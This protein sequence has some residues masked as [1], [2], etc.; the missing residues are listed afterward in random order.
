MSSDCRRIEMVVREGGRPLCESEKSDRSGSRERISSSRYGLKGLAQLLV[1]LL[2]RKIRNIEPPA[3]DFSP[4][5]FRYRCQITSYVRISRLLIPRGRAS[6]QAG[7]ILNGGLHN[8]LG[9]RTVTRTEGS[10]GGKRV[11][12]FLEGQR[13]LS[14]ADCPSTN[15]RAVF[16]LQSVAYLTDLPNYGNA[17]SRPIY[18]RK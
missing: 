2:L 14:F 9:L 8:L 11:H 1:R 18:S 4:S 12:G 6:W 17:F 16:F 15:R 5:N 10:R 13:P 7:A 3:C